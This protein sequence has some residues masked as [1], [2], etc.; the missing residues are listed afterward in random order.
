MA[1]I[2][3]TYSAPMMTEGTDEDETDPIAKKTKRVTFAMPKGDILPHEC[4]YVQRCQCWNHCYRMPAKI[5]LK[6]A[7]NQYIHTGCLAEGRKAKPKRRAYPEEYREYSQESAV[8]AHATA[9]TLRAQ[10][11]DFGSN[12]SDSIIKVRWHGT[13]IRPVAYP[14][15]VARIRSDGLVDIARLQ[16]LDPELDY[17][18]CMGAIELVSVTVRE[19]KRWHSKNPGAELVWNQLDLERSLRA[20]T[21][22][23]ATVRDRQMGHNEESTL[24]PKGTRCRPRRRCTARCSKP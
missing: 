17:P 16:K 7:C 10:V 21:S 2:T 12:E 3:M 24:A 4:P 22:Q 14:T 5:A 19:F 9:L 6:D 20:T 13:A 23:R 15:H 8:I 11:D 18:E 1:M